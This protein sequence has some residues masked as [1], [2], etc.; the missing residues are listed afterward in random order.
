MSNDEEVQSQAAS[1]ARAKLI[2]EAVTRTHMARRA[3]ISAANTIGDSDGMSIAAA[4]LHNATIDYYYALRPLSDKQAVKK[5]WNDVKLW[6]ETEVAYDA[7]T[8][9]YS[10]KKVWVTGFD[11]LDHEA[12]NRRVVTEIRDGYMGHRVV[13]R[14][15]PERLPPEVLLRVSAKLDEAT[16]KLGFMPPVKESL[17]RD[18]PSGSDLYG[19]LVKREQH[20]AARQLPESFKQTPKEEQTDV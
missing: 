16:A 15:V 10:S 17:P 7:E 13:Q 6:A 4:Q 20:E 11:A 1:A 14:E 18:E 12:V 3:Y 9:K 2:G 5:F 19:L 8:G